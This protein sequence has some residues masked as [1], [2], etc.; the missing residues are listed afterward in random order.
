MPSSRASRDAGIKPTTLMPLHWQAGFF[1]FFFVCLFVFC[2]L[3]TSATWEAH[4][5]FFFFVL[6]CGILVPDQGSNQRLMLW[7]C[8]V[9]S[10]RLSGKFQE[11][12]S[13]VAIPFS[14]GI[15]PTQGSNPDLPHCRWT[16]YLLS[17]Q[18]SL[19]LLSDLSNVQGSKW[20]SSLPPLSLSGPYS[21]MCL[22]FV[23]IVPEDF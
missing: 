1:V 11:Y 16:L 5:F 22:S 21:L 2:F 17:H 13:G 7:K 20:W 15:V 8:R 12:W 9:L 10:T 23:Y 18:G 19:K 6:G 14:R 4:F 3:T